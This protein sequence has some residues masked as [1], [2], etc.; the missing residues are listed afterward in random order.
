MQSDNPDPLKTD[1]SFEEA[2][3]KKQ[4][5][6]SKLT[7]VITQI[8]K[9]KL[10]SS[11]LRTESAAMRLKS[12]ATRIESARAKVESARAKVERTNLIH[13]KAQTSTESTEQIPESELLKVLNSVKRTTSLLRGATRI[14]QETTG[15]VLG[16]QSVALRDKNT[17]KRILRAI[18]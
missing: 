11:T 2:I 15:T 4:T 5:I 18:Q 8:R 12:R 16:N 13:K 10:E 9:L 3:Q 17:A 6:E 1:I 7:T 14:L